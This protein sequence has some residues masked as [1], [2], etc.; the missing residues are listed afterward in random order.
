M[1]IQDDTFCDF[2]SK[3][4][5]QSLSQATLGLKAPR[6]TAARKR[7]SICLISSVPALISCYIMNISEGIAYENGIETGFGIIGSFSGGVLVAAC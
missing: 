3:F 5:L 2:Y 7:Q 4:D 1:Q 6:K